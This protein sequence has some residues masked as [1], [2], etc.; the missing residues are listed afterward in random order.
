MSRRDPQL[1]PG[2]WVAPTRVRVAER[3]APYDVVIGTDLMGEL[4]GLLGGDVRRVG[5]IHSRALA[6]R[7][8]AV[9]QLLETDGVTASPVEVPDGEAAKTLDVA[10]S[11]W[12]RLGEAGFTRSDALVGVGGGAVTDLTGFVAASWLRG[13]RVVHVPTT[14]VGM[15]DAAIGG[16]TGLNTAYGKNL[17]GAFHH[18]AGVLCD[19]AVLAT[20]RRA[21]YVSGLAEVVKCGFIADPLLLDLIEADVVAASTPAAPVARELIERAVRVKAAV[22]AVDP[23]DQESPAAD[24]VG[25]AALNYG[26]TLGH[27]IEKLEGYRWRH[28][29]AVSVGLVFAAEVARR[30][31]RLDGDTA[32]RHGAVLSALDLP[33]GYRRDAWPAL[34][35]AMRLDKKSRGDRLRLVVLDGLAHPAILDN[36]DTELLG[37]AYRSVC[38]P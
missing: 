19:L 13:V 31:G 29:D 22:V 5:V 30:A 37:A 4:A 3:S 12:E 28:G 9:C 20:L 35:A 14:L 8:Q 25:R 32:A 38:S 15:V 26:H 11:C 34:L 23:T 36:P 18:P 16:K 1:T 6:D 17:V 2:P 24:G 21:D 27:A 7:A 10:A 33:T